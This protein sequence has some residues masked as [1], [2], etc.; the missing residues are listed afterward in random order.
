MVP[1]TAPEQG[2]G[3]DQDDLLPAGWS[4]PLGLHRHAAGPERPG[5]ADPVDGRGEGEDHSLREDP[6][7]G[8]PLRPEVG[9]VPGSTAG[10][11]TGPNAVRQQSGR[12]PLEE[13]RGTMHDLR[14]TSA[15]RGGGLRRSTIGSGAAEADRRRRRTWSCSTSTVIGRS[16]C[17]NDGRKR[18]RPARGVR[19]RL[20]W[21]RGNSHVQF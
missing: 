7:R 15:S 20:S 10:L 12:I 5:L 9:T 11:A 8:Q 1:A 21:M 19:E 18:P 6:Q 14:P 16:T 3:M 13:A 2:P 4:S 17:K